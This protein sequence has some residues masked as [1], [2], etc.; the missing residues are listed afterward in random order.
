MSD[1]AEVQAVLARAR[2]VMAAHQ[3][4]A[5]WARSVSS[6]YWLTQGFNTA[7]NTAADAGIASILVTPE[8]A[9]AIT[10]TIE[11][12]RVKEEGR[13][14]VLG[15]T[16]HADP[17]WER[18]PLGFI[19]SVVG[20]GTI[21]SDLPV[22]PAIVNVA[23]ALA[24]ERSKLSAA[25]QDKARQAGK[26]TAAGLRAAIEQVQPGMTEA[27]IAAILDYE[28]RA[29]GMTPIVNLIATDERICKYRHPLPTEKPLE[30]YAMLVICARYEGLVLNTT[31]L[32]H[33]GPPPEQTRQKMEA[34][35]R[36]DAKAIAATRPGAKLSEIFSVIQ[37]AY[38]AEG[39]PGEWKLHHQGGPGGYA[40]R[41]GFA[42]P[43]NHQ[44]VYA[45][46]LMAW[47]PSITGVKC[48]DTILVTGDGFENLTKTDNWPT[49]AVEVG[50]QL[51]ERP[52]IWQR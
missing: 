45:G 41:E 20:S 1:F 19:K 2:Q 34:C 21:G 42:T 7:V 30:T 23:G 49:L 4:D 52:L 3:L 50:G 38:A 47:N 14:E 39:Y 13:A 31:R 5:L 12:L 36:V 17:W 15:F 40:G 26:R 29:R 33:F 32:V 48:E 43:T 6:V 46:Q 11:A 44:A 24:L 25:E 28:I 18:D 10:D 22:S 51:I 27:K 16:L 37:D 35:C 8:A 9:Y